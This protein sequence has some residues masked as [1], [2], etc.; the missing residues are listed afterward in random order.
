MSTAFRGL[1]QC[2]PLSHPSNAE[3]YPWV[4]PKAN[5]Q[6]AGHSPKLDTAF[7]LVVRRCPSYLRVDPACQRGGEVPSHPEKHVL[8]L[9]RPA[10]G[11][12]LTPG[13]HLGDASLSSSI[14]ILPRLRCPPT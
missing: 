14:Q 8:P 4:V 13:G 9:G 1:V 11:T 3:M 7:A 5:R 12:P 10:G 6:W 2:F